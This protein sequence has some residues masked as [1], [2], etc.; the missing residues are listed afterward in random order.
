MHRSMYHKRLQVDLTRGRLVKW[1]V[2]SL[3]LCPTTFNSCRRSCEA[4]FHLPT[5]LADAWSSCANERLTHANLHLCTY[6]LPQP[7][8]QLMLLFLILLCCSFL[9]LYCSCIFFVCTISIAPFQNHINWWQGQVWGGAKDGPP[10]PKSSKKKKKRELK[11]NHLKAF[12]FAHKIKIF[13]W[14]FSIQFFG[15]IWPNFLVFV[16]K[17]YRATSFI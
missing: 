4:I 11:K 16:P 17:K 12:G 7:H 5:L 3:F 8:L 6:C 1:G 2:M 9:A 10:T 15:S 14:F 13:I